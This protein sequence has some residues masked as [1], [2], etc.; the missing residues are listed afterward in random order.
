MSLTCVP[1]SSGWS[2]TAAI[3]DVVTTKSYDTSQGYHKQTLSGLCGLCLLVD[4]VGQPVAG[5]K[6]TTTCDLCNTRL[7]YRTVQGGR[8]C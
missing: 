5:S 2:V 3:V 1:L 8:G 4:P 6:S 7:L